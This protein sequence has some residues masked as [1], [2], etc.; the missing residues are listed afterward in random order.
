MQIDNEKKDCFVT[1]LERF[2]VKNFLFSSSFDDISQ[3][4]RD[5]RQRVKNLF[6]ILF[7]IVQAVRYTVILSFDIF[8][9]ADLETRNTWGSI[10]YF[11]GVGEKILFSASFT[12]TLQSLWIRMLCWYKERNN[13]LHF[14]RDIEDYKLENNKTPS[15]TGKFRKEFLSMAQGRIKKIKARRCFL[16]TLLATSFYTFTAL[17]CISLEESFSFKRYIFWMFYSF[18]T[19]I[20]IRVTVVMVFTISGLWH[21]SRYHCQLLTKQLIQKLE[22]IIHRLNGQHLKETTNELKHFI[23]MFKDCQE[24]IKQFNRFSKHLVT[25]IA[26]SSSLITSLF[27]LT[28]IRSESATASRIF[29]PAT[30]IM[31]FEPLVVM[32]TST[33]LHSL[34]RELHQRLNDCFIRL[35][36]RSFIRQRMAIRSLIKDVSNPRTNSITLVHADN[37]ACCP[38]VFLQFIGST[39]TLF[40]MLLE[41][42]D[43]FRSEF[44][45]NKELSIV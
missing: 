13:D 35:H 7:L 6:I 4:K 9:K 42:V 26:V 37:S 8:M 24:R 21:I 25:C 33:S 20:H 11:M 27:I 31:S 16:L 28:V 30:C 45:R 18:L 23:Q 3:G 12:T 29:F 19:W 43:S 17:Y 10:Y 14:L 44:I 2:L 32:A 39:V 1:Q 36:R 41:F 34:S 40:I 22:R 15:L 38:I 5:R